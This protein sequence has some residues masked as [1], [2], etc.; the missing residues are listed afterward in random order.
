MPVKKDDEISDTDTDVFCTK[1]LA[2]LGITEY[3]SFDMANLVA[4]FAMDCEHEGK[5]W[6]RQRQRVKTLEFQTGFIPDRRKET[7]PKCL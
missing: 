3:R 5:L 4:Q 7:L 1:L 2:L 6:E